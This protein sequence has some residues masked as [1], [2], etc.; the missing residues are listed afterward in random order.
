MIVKDVVTFLGYVL[1][2]TGVAIIF[3]GAGTAIARHGYR[4]IIARGGSPYLNFRETMGRAMLVGLDFLVAGDIIRTVIVDHTID[5]VLGLGLIVII[6]TILAFT[7]HLEIEG[8]W[9]WQ[10]RPPEDEKPPA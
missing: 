10:S 9:P 6:R 2:F 4:R 7:I 8:H 5:A 1:E 3:L